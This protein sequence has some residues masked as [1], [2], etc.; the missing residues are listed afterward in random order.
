VLLGISLV[1]GL[2]IVGGCVVAAGGDFGGEEGLAFVGGVLI[3][4]ILVG[5]VFLFTSMSRDLR[6]LRDRMN[7]DSSEPERDQEP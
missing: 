3:A 5:A 6:L 7:R 4:V 1:A 2:G